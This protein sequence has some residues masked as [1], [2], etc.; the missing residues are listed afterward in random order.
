MWAHVYIEKKLNFPAS[1][2]IR[3]SHVTKFGQW[4]MSRN[5]VCS[6]QILPFLLSPSLAGMLMGQLMLPSTQRWKL[7]VERWMTDH[8]W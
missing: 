6:F 5:D 2:A 7:P 4:Y 8:P 1:L 3:C